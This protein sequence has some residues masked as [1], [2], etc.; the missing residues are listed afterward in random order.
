MTDGHTRW[1][2]VRVDDQVR[3]DTFLRERHVFL[4][5]GHS[6][7]SFLTMSRG[8]FVTDLWDSDRSHFDLGEPITILVGCQDDLID[9]SFLRMFE[10]G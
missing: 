2:S 10:L 1:D 9:H 6:N 7:S 3:A 8:E 4:S 5:V